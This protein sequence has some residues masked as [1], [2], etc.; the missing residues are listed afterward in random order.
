[1]GSS[2]KERWVTAGLLLYF[3]PPKEKHSLKCSFCWKSWQL[4]SSPCVLSL[5]LSAGQLWG[6]GH[7][8][9]WWTQIVVLTIVWCGRRDA[10]PVSRRDERAA[11]LQD[12]PGTLRSTQGSP[13][14]EHNNVYFLFLILVFWKG[15]LT[16][17]YMYIMCFHLSLPL[18]ISSS[19]TNSIPAF[20][21]DF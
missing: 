5:R 20:I 18:L 13:S 12:K 16:I 2:A 1:M 19:P 8:T 10:V 17:A 7:K 6:R 9:L 21:L 4:G 3:Q 11:I 14:V 15:V